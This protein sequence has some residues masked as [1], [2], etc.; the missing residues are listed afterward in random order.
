[1]NELSAKITNLSY[2]IFG[3]IL[4]GLIAELFFVAW[5]IALGSAAPIWTLELLPQLT[6]ETASELVKSLTVNTGIG[7]AVPGIVAAYFIGHIL[8][9]VGRSSTPNDRSSSS[10]LRRVGYSLIFRIPKPIESYSSHLKPLFEAVE[11]KFR[12]NDLQLNW[13]QFFPLAK[14]YLSTN[15]VSSLVANYQNKYTLH[16]SITTAA[17]LLFWVCILAIGLGV[18]CMRWC[19]IS[20]VP[21]WGPLVILDFFSLV[22]VWGFSDSYLYHW[23]MFGN[24]IV[25]ETYSLI[26]G[27]PNVRPKP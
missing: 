6:S 1:M 18:V 10:W 17:T 21:R 24:T 27:P 12:T 8:H 25:T 16:R 14:C 13:A 19:S 3:V 7:I 11:P 22:L 15:L 26:L 4:P 23:K 2:E 5:W 9:W 20:V